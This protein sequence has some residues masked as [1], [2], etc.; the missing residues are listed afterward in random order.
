[1]N[2]HQKTSPKPHI[3]HLPKPG[4]NVSERK[5]PKLLHLE[6]LWAPKKNQRS[7]ST[8]HSPWSEKPWSH[9]DPSEAPRTK[10]ESHRATGQPF[11]NHGMKF[12]CIF[13]HG[14]NAAVFFWTNQ[15]WETLGC[16]F[17]AAQLSNP[18][19]IDVH[20]SPMS[21]FIGGYK[22]LWKKQLMS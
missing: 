1:M 4:P 20:N 3:I 11:S 22:F 5:L 12:R 14:K 8:A 9:I 19:I 7:I 18:K 6:I 2:V 15:L 17:G 21:V 10:S 13:S 16:V